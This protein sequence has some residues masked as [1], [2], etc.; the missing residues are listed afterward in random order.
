MKVFANY[1]VCIP[2]RTA[3]SPIYFLDTMTKVLNYNPVLDIWGNSIYEEPNKA[4]LGKYILKDFFYFMD[5]VSCGPSCK[6]IIK[7]H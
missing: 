3:S 4:R 2:T 7:K 5:D 6:M 1:W